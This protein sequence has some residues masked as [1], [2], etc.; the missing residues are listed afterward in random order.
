MTSRPSY[1][2]GALARAATVAN[3]ARTVEAAAAAAGEPSRERKYSGF[4]C[5]IIKACFL[6]Y[7]DFHTATAKLSAGRTRQKG[8]AEYLI[9]MHLLNIIILY[10]MFRHV[11][12]VFCT[13]LAQW[14]GRM[15]TV[16]PGSIHNSSPEHLIGKVALCQ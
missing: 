8:Q 15:V 10:Q 3:P 13:R 16:A 1:S 4:G 12:C 6:F 9:G 7:A 5:G 11:R 2:S 14:P